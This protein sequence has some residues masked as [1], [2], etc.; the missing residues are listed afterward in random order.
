[1]VNLALFVR[2]EAKPGKEEEVA[3]FL[4]GAAPLVEAEH[5]TTAW[6]AIR[7]GLSTFAIFDAF[8]NEP[9]R[10]AHLSGK[11]AEALIAKAPDLFAHPP[12]IEKA[13]VLASK[14]P[15]HHAGKPVQEEKIPM[16]VGSELRITNKGELSLGNPELEL[17]LLDGAA[18][19]ML[20][21]RFDP[22]VGEHV[23]RLLEPVAEHRALGIR[24]ATE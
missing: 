2:M 7:L 18:D 6:F 19:A 4:K 16:Q 22:K 8:P 3:A 21:Y 23:I 1:M 10:Q 5:A 17:G 20:S 13:G 12:V 11:V 14:L 9:G 15:N 24:R